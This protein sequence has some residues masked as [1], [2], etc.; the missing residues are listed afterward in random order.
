MVMSMSNYVKAYEMLEEEED[1]EKLRKH[2]KY[3]LVGRAM[4][5]NA[6]SEEEA[7]ALAEYSSMD[8]GML[9]GVIVH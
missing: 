7:V 6:L 8:L 1:I 9:E 3:I 5:D 4:I 2:A